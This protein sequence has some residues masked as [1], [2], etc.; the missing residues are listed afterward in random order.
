MSIKWSDSRRS[1]LDRCPRQ[2]KYK[3]VDKLP[4]GEPS[5]AMKRG[6]AADA[7]GD[8]LLVATDGKSLSAKMLRTLAKFKW[9]DMLG[10][11]EA[12]LP[13]YPDELATKAI[14]YGIDGALMLAQEGWRL[15]CDLESGAPLV[16]LHLVGKIAG[17]AFHGYADF[18]CQNAAHERAI[19]DRKISTVNGYNTG[20]VCVAPQL[21]TYCLLAAQHTHRLGRIDHTGIL[22]TKPN[23]VPKTNLYQ[24]P[25]SK[26]DSRECSDRIAF[27]N[28]MAGYY[29]EHDF[30]PRKVNGAYESP[31]GLCDYR[32]I[33]FPQSQFGE[34]KREAIT[35]EIPKEKAA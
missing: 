12:K 11:I 18:I 10:A 4:R 23:K 3:Y 21:A 32:E 19:F 1:T 17:V 30:W 29:V 35:G 24:V 8:V 15:A 33:C 25:V 6:L 28:V 14:G 22:V 34:G 9:D 5:E 26:I 31:C 20:Y 7:A 16:Q 27:A 13:G 2:Y